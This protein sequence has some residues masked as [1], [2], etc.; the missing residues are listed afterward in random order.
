MSILARF[1]LVLGF[2]G[3]VIAF[4]LCFMSPPPAVGE[5]APAT[6][7]SSARALK[8]L[9]VIAAHPHPVGSAEHQIVFDY[10]VQQ[11]S[12]LN[13][14]PEIQTVA[15]DNSR[16]L[17]NILVRLK[18]SNA[19][20][21][22]LMLTA[23]YDSVAGSPGAS[24][25]GSGVVT[26]L[27]TLRALKAGSPLQNDVIFL[28][29]DGEE[30][31]ARGARAFIDKHAWARDAGLVLN[32]EARGSSGPVVM[33][34]TS[35]SNG[36]LIKELS[37]VAPRP[38]T[39][40][41]MDELYQLMG[42][43][44]DLTVFKDAGLAGLNFAYIDSAWDYHNAR[45]NISNID[46][47]SIQHHG[48]YALTL[49]RHFG[50]FDLRNVE[51]P[52]AIYFDVLGRKV[53]TYPQ[54]WNLPLTVILV[55]LATGV[56]IV[57]V[58]AGRIAFSGL[59]F[60]MLLFVVSSVCALVLTMLLSKLLPAVGPSAV[61]HLVVLLLLVAS[62]VLAVYIV[63]TRRIR[64]NELSGGALLVLVLVAVA[65]N[66]ALPGGSF[67]LTWPLVF[68]LIALGASFVLPERFDSSFLHSVLVGACSIPG[69][70]LFTQM[71]DNVFQGFSLSAPYV[72]VVLELLLLGLLTPFLKSFRHERSFSSHR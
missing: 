25:D 24:D 46:E 69:I 53:F 52:D 55:L 59:V 57:G 10:L 49:T 50:D 34:E 13:G 67:L 45:D 62:M 5:G 20:G 58:R 14:P 38:F 11:L 72:L 3:G 41:L 30:L 12:R 9:S 36:T 2:V 8:H 60:G 22:A 66:V 65:V 4:T 26:L 64:I 54:T 18:G 71:L 21:K 40:S 70:V 17:Q 42:N 43:L 37:R 15:S 44:T 29:T 63:A 56:S 39:N 19:G 51:G 48:S 32:F 23:H 33:F 27:E 35:K 6:E 1:A 61:Y 16:P 47:R 68:S 31:G 7:F 28:F